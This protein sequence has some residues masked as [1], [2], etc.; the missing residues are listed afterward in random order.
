MIVHP[1]SIENLIYVG[2][3][4]QVYMHADTGSS[5]PIDMSINSEL[6]DMDN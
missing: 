2:T 5:T 6:S 3:R 4:G 1:E